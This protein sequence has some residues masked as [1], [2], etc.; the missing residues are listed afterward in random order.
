MEG[1]E[2]SENFFRSA[3]FSA[4][5]KPLL[6][7]VMQV[8]PKVMKIVTASAN[9][10]KAAVTSFTKKYKKDGYVEYCLGL[11]DF[12]CKKL[13]FAIFLDWFVCFIL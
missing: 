4:I 8:V 3:K 12:L 9:D 7:L 2:Q 13:T 10:V 5:T 1:I 6:N 11:L